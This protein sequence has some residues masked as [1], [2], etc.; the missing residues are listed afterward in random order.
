MTLSKDYSDY[1][2][3]AWF[4]NEYWGQMYS[5]WDLPFFEKLLLQ[6]LAQGAH[7]LDLCCG[8][9]HLAQQMLRKG[10]QVTGVDSSKAMLEYANQNAPSGKF[11]LGDVRCLELSPKFSGVAS[12]GGFNHIM[13]IE[14]LTGV[15]CSVYAALQENG[16]FVFNLLSE[17]R[18][19]LAWNGS[20]DGGDVKD[21]YAWASRS[22][23]NPEEKTG[24]NQITIFQL[25]E[26]KW[27]RSDI[28]LLVRDYSKIE[29][30]SALENAGFTAVRV[31]DSERDFG[32]SGSLGILW[33]V[34]RK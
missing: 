29:I 18:F 34:C 14:E 3:F 27:H 15:F 26:G 28:N 6:H 5:E 30:Q 12:T 23:Y 1:D 9:G 19:K 24:C 7:I 2:P 13:S 17:E 20:L 16:L 21:D 10:Y 31:Y 22:S 32:V 33:Y 4:Y 8:T 11:I 25:S